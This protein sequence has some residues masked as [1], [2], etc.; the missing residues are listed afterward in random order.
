MREL[1]ITEKPSAAKKI[2]AALAESKVESK[3]ANGVNY[4]VVKHKGKT[5]T[6][7][8]A[9][10]HL[11][12]VA[13]KKK[14]FTY[15]VFDIDWKPVYEDNKKAIYAK[16]YADTIR[17]EAK[18]SGSFVVACDYD[19][20]GEVIGLN[21]IRFLCN[22]KD[23][24]RMKFST[25]T[26]PDLVEA[27]DS[28][29]K[30]L[31][32][33]QALA[34]ETRHFLDWMYGINLSRALTLAIR[35]NK[36]YRTMSSGRVQGPA[37]KLL[38]KREK[39]IQ[40][41]KPRPYWQ[42]QLLGACHKGDIE[43]W[44]HKDKF[45][46]ERQV[47]DILKKTKGHKGII[48]KLDRTERKHPP[49]TPFDLTS[50]QT[51]AYGTIGLTPKRA[52]DTAQELYIKGYISYPRT[53][54]QQL[55]DKIGYRKIITELMKQSKYAK[56]GQS[57][58]SKKSL[59]PNNGKKTDPAHPAIYPTGLFPKDI[60]GPQQ[61]LYDLI[62]KRF[63]ATFGDWA[64]RETMTITIDV[65]T[66]D[67]I[68]K[69]TRTTQKGWYGLY[70][71][72]L[73][74]KE[75]ELPEVK[76][77]DIVNVKKITKLEKETQPPKRFTEA[78]IINELEDRNLGTKATRAQ[79]IENLYEREY[80]QGKSIEVTRLGMQT[81]ETL[82][83]HSPKIL[84]EELTQFFEEEMEG[85]REKKTTPEKILN[86]AKAELRHILVDFKKNELNIGKKL[87]K[88]YIETEREKSFV[89][90]CP[91]CKKGELHIIH[92]KKNNSRFIACDKYPD[93]K[94]TFSIPKTGEVKGIGQ[95]CEK[96]GYPVIEIRKGKIPKR[97]CINPLCSGKKPKDKLI[98]KEESEMVHHV[99]EEE[100]PKCKEGV[101]VVKKSMYGHFLGCSRFPKC[102]YTQ[103]IKDGPLKE[104][105]KK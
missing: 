8:P 10:G 16:K 78:S 57:L 7:V 81:I 62:V 45:W 31:D 39:E 95:T 102:R 90:P 88:A 86:K 105:F 41:F 15:P 82:E 53:S 83:E 17:A 56:L 4:Y 91:V 76:L 61:R 73:R 5:I 59:N 6:I 22:K 54:S 93:C 58:L 46:Q 98:R 35:K 38:C 72:Y 26:A 13:E 70:E 75:E 29:S 20:E 52:L 32:W 71:P 96:C 63:F 69:G 11:F 23:A 97:L 79:I 9:V 47:D 74:L 36:A 2:A 60:Q 30:T 67:F 77:Q 87:A 104:D 94:T 19:I 66:E 21:A 25:L 44:H 55:P 64:A 65:N 12:T 37:L 14:S 80:I 33:G 103:N 40:K 42:L 92:N 34:G 1:I 43:A 51:E 50:L 89:G 100:C 101:L 3:R 84:D 85:I 68:A 49:P 28:M 99:V 18:F 24:K 48:K 27:Y